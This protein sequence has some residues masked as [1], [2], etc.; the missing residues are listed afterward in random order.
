[1]TQQLPQG[2]LTGLRVLDLSAIVAAPLSAT[3]LA[4]YGADVLKVELPVVGDSVRGYPPMK[5][6]ASLWW[7]VANRNKKLI[8]LDVRRPEGLALFKRLI[9]RFDALV[10]NFR[11][12]TLDK[13]G[14]SREVLWE[15][16]PR[17]V[18]LRMMII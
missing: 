17:L 6:G 5:D 16:Q 9:G 15:L 7:K 1:M 13:W 11:P 2:P 8:T 12:G 14:L 18:I 4:D 10:E 3:L